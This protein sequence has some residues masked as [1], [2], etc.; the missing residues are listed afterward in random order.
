MNSSTSSS[1]S[2]TAQ[3][4]QRF[5]R[6]F[7]GGAAGLGGFL[8][9]LIFLIDP[10]DTLPFSPPLDRAPI[11]SNA[12]F[13]FPALARNAQYD[14]VVIGTSTARLLRPDV[15]N[16]LFS[17]RF[18]NLSMNSATAYEQFRLAE[19]FARHHPAAKTVI[20]GIDLV[21]CTPGKEIEKYT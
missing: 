11:A 1:D 9:L 15:L 10:F 14:S 18:A 17:A 19:V 6:W 5:A 7:F 3:G 2:A 21:W 4:W 16:S 20:F 12:R 8:Y 13:S